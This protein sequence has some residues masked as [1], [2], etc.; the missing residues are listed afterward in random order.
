MT[1]APSKQAE[2]M[3]LLRDGGS[4]AATFRAT[5]VARTAQRRIWENAGETWPPPG[6]GTRARR[7]HTAV[8]PEQAQAARALIAAGGVKALIAEAL[9]VNQSTLYRALKRL[10]ADWALPGEGQHSAPGQPREG[11][12]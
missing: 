12:H 10:E 4:L 9:G 2:V 8:T 7:Q 3:R 6:A 5:G 11:H 1:T